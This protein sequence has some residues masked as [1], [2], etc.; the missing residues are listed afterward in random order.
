MEIATISSQ[1]KVTSCCPFLVSSET[2]VGAANMEGAGLKEGK[3]R[4]KYPLK[5]GYV[6]CSRHFHFHCWLVKEWHCLC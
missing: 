5:C 4:R 1:F 3:K 6:F 2:E